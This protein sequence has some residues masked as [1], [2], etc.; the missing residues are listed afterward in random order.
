MK[1]TNSNYYYYHIVKLASQ[2][3][4]PKEYFYIKRNLQL[5][6]WFSKSSSLVGMRLNKSQDE[7]EKGNLCWKIRK[8]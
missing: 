7:V 1:K 8:Y 4:A 2:R 3:S 5:G 6:P